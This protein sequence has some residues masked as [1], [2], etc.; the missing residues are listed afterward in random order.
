LSGISRKLKKTQLEHTVNLGAI[1]RKEKKVETKQTSENY[2]GF[3]PNN[4]ISLMWFR[5]V[6]LKR[7]VKAG[8]SPKVRLNMDLAKRN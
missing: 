7:P 1:A 5:G 2:H 4:N 6:T 3:Q 8:L